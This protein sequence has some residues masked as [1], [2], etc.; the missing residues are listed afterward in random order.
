MSVNVKCKFASLKYEQL[1]SD[2]YF[3]ETCFSKKYESYTAKQKL[4]DLYMEIK[5]VTKVLSCVL[6]V[7]TTTTVCPP[8]TTTTTTSTTTTTTTS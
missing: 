1:L 4:K 6:S 5:M 7:T 3:I 2:K 8:A